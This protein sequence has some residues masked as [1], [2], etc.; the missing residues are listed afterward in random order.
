VRN[1]FFHNVARADGTRGF[2]EIGHRTGVAYAEG[3]VRG[4]MGI[5]W[6]WDYRP[7]C[8][9]LLIGN[10][11]NE[12]NTFLCQ[13]DPRD[14]LLFADVATSE[15]VAGPS[16]E[17]LKFGVFFFDYDLD[18]RL[19]LLTC[20]GHLDPEIN[21]VQRSQFY[22]QPV[23]LFWNT[24]IDGRGFEPVTKAAA[25]PDLF[26]PL[27]GR[28][29]A[30]LDFNGDGH[31]DVVLTANGG[32]ARLLQN[33]GNSGNHWLRLEL[34]GDGVR[35]NRSAIGAKVTLEAGGRVQRREVASGRGYL[36]QSE[37]VLTFGLGKTAKVDRIT[38]EWPGR[39][40]GK[41]VLENVTDVDRVVTISQKT[42]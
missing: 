16:R 35:S 27:V 19:D 33:N 8:N 42:E 28:G 11:A 26:K 36:S 7:G 6:A 40:G 20:N 30:F 21:T 3:G 2:E 13:N 38:I 17:F 32:P 4:A 37:L 23:Q 31:L 12:P 34:G 41:Q 15:G 22:E 9:G 18:G 29:C 25:G 1:F 14:R 39:K 24:G 5:D 10:F